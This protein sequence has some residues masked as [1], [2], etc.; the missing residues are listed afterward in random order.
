[1]N[2]DVLGVAAVYVQGL[3]RRTKRTDDGLYVE[4]ANVDLG[5][6]TVDVA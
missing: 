2:A 6:A 5:P 1:L 4:F 3:G